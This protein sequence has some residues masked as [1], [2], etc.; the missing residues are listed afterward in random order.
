[1]S[2][3]IQVSAELRRALRLKSP[4][5]TAR[6][7]S[8]LLAAHLALLIGPDLPPRVLAARV[9]VLRALVV[10]DGQLS[11]RELYER[12]GGVGWLA[13]TEHLEALLERGLVETVESTR[14][15]R[16]VRLRLY[17]LAHME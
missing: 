1:V 2:R 9:R 14:R 10:T 8:L 16:G 12:T 17:T 11:K 6:A 13:F 4:T 5:A 3:W 7:A 15:Y